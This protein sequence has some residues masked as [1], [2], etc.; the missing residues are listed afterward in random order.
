MVSASWDLTQGGL[1]VDV[2]QQLSNEGALAHDHAAHAL[3]LPGVGIVPGLAIEPRA[4]A[5]ITLTQLNARLGGT[6]GQ[7]RSCDLQQSAVGRMR[8]VLLLHRGVNGDRSQFAGS[9]GL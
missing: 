1:A 4:G 9:D 3:V 6:L 5:G 2:T 7:L 8:D